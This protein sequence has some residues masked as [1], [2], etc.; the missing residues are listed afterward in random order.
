M[1]ISEDGR[2]IKAVFYIIYNLNKEGLFI[3]NEK[4]YSSISCG[5]CL[6]LHHSFGVEVPKSQNG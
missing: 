2:L 4:N 5:S 6:P 3:P 1:K